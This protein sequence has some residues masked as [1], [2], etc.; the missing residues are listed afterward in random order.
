[1]TIRLISFAVV[2]AMSVFMS[3]YSGGFGWNFAKWLCVFTIIYSLVS[4]IVMKLGLKVHNENVKVR[5]VR[6]SADKVSV[7]L[8]SRFSL[9]FSKVIIQCS[10]GKVLADVPI[11]GKKSVEY[12]VECPHCGR[13]FHGAEKV[14]ITDAFGLFKIKHKM[15]KKAVLTTVVPK[16]RQLKKRAYTEAVLPC[17]ASAV[18]KTQEH[19]E[20]AGVRPFESGDTVKNIHWKQSARRRE[21]MTTEYEEPADS[22]ILLV[23]NRNCGAKYGDGAETAGDLA[24]EYAISALSAVLERGKSVHSVIISGD[25][26]S[27]RDVNCVQKTEDAEMEFAELKPV[28][29]REMPFVSSLLKCFQQYSGLVYV[30]FEQNEQ[31]SGI[32]KKLAGMGMHTQTVLV[33]V[34]TGEEMNT[35]YLNSENDIMNMQVP[36]GC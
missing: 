10:V 35:V 9:P 13:Y 15:Q 36:Y 7:R 17:S 30:C 22:K 11:H 29:S 6:G 5:A 24:G 21:L 25:I 18:R 12:E 34:G 32:M 1:M 20:V 31:I 26:V 3:E 14:Y 19:E 23:V 2:T 4:V 27:E 33:G 28:F 8:E 16:I